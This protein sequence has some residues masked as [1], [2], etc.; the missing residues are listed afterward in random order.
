LAEK[1]RFIILGENSPM[2]ADKRYYLL[3]V[4]Y[5]ISAFTVIAGAVMKIMHYSA[6]DFL[7]MANFFAIVGF[8]ILAGY[9]VMRSKQIQTVEKVMWLVSFVFLLSIAGLLY[10][11]MR[12]KVVIGE[13]PG[14]HT[15]KDAGDGL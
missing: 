8:M 14:L 2:Q 7:L 11:A 6:G 3:V 10:L 4:L 15:H 5:L 9:E 12:R 1:V 13:V